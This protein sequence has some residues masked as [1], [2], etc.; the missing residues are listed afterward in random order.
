MWRCCCC[1]PCCWQHQFAW[2]NRIRIRNRSGFLPVGSLAVDT[3]PMIT[4]HIIIPVVYGAGDTILL[5]IPLSNIATKGKPTTHTAIPITTILVIYGIIQIRTIT[6]VATGDI[7][8]YLEA[9]RSSEFRGSLCFSPT[10]HHRMHFL[11]RIQKRLQAPHPW[12]PSGQAWHFT[13]KQLAL[14]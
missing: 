4:V 13:L 14:A 8:D 7:D 3:L 6:M 2:H 1:W 11:S 5:M 10:K 12:P 9:G